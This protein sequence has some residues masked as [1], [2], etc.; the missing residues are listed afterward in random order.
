[1]LVVDGERLLAAPNWLGR[2]AVKE[3][4]ETVRKLAR[5]RESF[6]MLLGTIVH[7]AV[8]Q[9]ML[10]RNNKYRKRPPSS[11]C[12]NLKSPA[13]FGRDDEGEDSMVNIELPSPFTRFHVFE[14]QTNVLV[15]FHGV[16]KVRLFAWNVF[17][18]IN[19]QNSK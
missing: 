18:N 7:L 13:S 16:K 4:T 9:Q 11:C 19:T 10:Y 6:M 8:V 3:V 5:A 14:K 15:R 1:M 17:L 12:Q 2:E